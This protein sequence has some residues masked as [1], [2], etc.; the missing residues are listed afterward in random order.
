MTISCIS[1]EEIKRYVRI[2]HSDEDDL[3][4]A[5]GATATELIETR[6]RR[7]IIAEDD[8]TAV[9]TSPEKVPQSIKIAACIIVT[10]MYENRSATDVELRDRV[11]RQ[12]LLDQYIL[13][14][15]E[16]EAAIVG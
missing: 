15:D 2:D 1:L 12:A 10:F 14:G 3:L 8:S 5:F 6:I 16:D 13:W 4:E 9:A 11:M 7:P